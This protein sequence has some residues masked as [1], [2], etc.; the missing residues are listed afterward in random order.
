MIKRIRPVLEAPG[1]LG[2][3]LRQNSHSRHLQDV[4]DLYFL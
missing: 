4:A 2:S 1:L 3:W